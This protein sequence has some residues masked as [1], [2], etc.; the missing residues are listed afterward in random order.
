MRLTAC[1]RERQKEHPGGV[2]LDTTWVH[3][4]L[5]LEFTREADG[6]V[7]ALFTNKSRAGINPRVK[8]D[9]RNPRTRLG[10]AVTDFN[11]AC[12][13]LK[14][15]GRNRSESKLSADK[16]PEQSKANAGK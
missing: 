7:S 13:S 8:S 15:E 3:K 16:I 6:N 5:G 10:R 9:G 1:L 12:E 2:F 4:N 11:A 14:I